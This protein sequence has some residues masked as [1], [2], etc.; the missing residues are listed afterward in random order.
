M[1]KAKREGRPALWQSGAKMFSV[2]N[3][4]PP[5]G[6]SD[7]GP[8]D[9]F[10]GAASITPLKR[11]RSLLI[12][13]ATGVSNALTAAIE[14]EFRFLS[15]HT[16]SDFAE[17]CKS[18]VPNVDLIVVDRS[19]VGALCYD[20]AELSAWHPRA[21]VAV[22]ADIG[23]QPDQR[24]TELVERRIVMGI[25][26]T[27]SNLDILLSIFRILLSG[28]EYVPSALFRPHPAGSEQP[29][30]MKRDR[31]MG[32][33]TT[34]EWQILEHVAKGS[35]NKIIASDLG[36]SEHT[37]KIHIHNIISKLGVHN[38]TE[39]AAVYFAGRHRSEIGNGREPPHS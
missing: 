36:L 8:G 11:E 15:V 33:L 5:S 26:P 32:D 39:A 3:Q 34:R 37:V 20:H 31:A 4:I 19:M 22:L 12:V 35:Q 23:Q 9:L 16:V 21:T 29:T 10:Q 25:L 13:S 18:P 24:L 1:P 7:R 30:H 6:A 38:R 27:G 14:C 2:T 17:A 28:G